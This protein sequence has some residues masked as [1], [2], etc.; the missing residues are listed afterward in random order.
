MATTNLG[1]VRIT[2]GGSFD[3]TLSYQLLTVV[4]NPYKVKYISKTDVPTGTSLSDTTYWEP[5]SGNFVEQYQGALSS[6]PTL[7]LDGSNLLDGDLYANTTDNKMYVYLSSS[8]VYIGNADGT[9]VFTKT[10][11]VTLA[12]SVNENSSI[13]GS[14]TSDVGTTTILI[15]DKGTITNHDVVAKTFTYTSYDITNGLNGLDTIT[16]YSTKAGEIR[17]ADNITNVTVV[18]VPIA[19]DGTISNANFATNVSTSTGFTL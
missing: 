17:S 9:I 7:R 12:S 8:W 6:N 11:V 15:A 1:K 10:P 19:G 13:N 5:L 4:D 3:S 16:A 2:F 14:Y 18:Y